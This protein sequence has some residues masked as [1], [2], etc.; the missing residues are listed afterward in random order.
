MKNIISL[1]DTTIG[2]YNLGNNVI[3]DAVNEEL[4]ALFPNTQIYR[5]APM[6][7]GPY[8]RSCL[9]KSDLA[10]FGGTNS[11]NGDLFKYKQWDL[12]LRN[13]HG[14]SNTVLLGLGW[15][16]YEKKPITT[17]SKYLFTKA[18]TK[19]YLHSVRDNYTKEKLESIG[20]NSI[21]TGCPTIW[22]LTPEK[23]SSI[24]STKRPGVV[25]TI[26]D[27]NKNVERDSKMINSCLDNYSEVYFFPQ[28]TG[29]IEYVNS[30]IDLN[31]IKILKPRIEDFNKVLDSD[32]DYIGTRL[33]AGIRA[34]QKGVHS[35]IIGIDNRALEKKKDIGLLVLDET[36]INHLDEL[37]KKRTPI[38]LDIPFAEIKK[39]R[40]QFA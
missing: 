28:G 32:V 16:Q 20:I 26:T 38:K 31:K 12:R 2:S 10:F 24:P 29:D 19:N 18:L 6:D 23:L 8:S 25:F 21:N 1:F 27:Y 3:M 35:I 14:I 17:Y 13:I 9:M 36:E 15:W 4:D 37:I 7:I 33:H 5:L 22:N 34:L 30:M 11:L 39:W 40:K